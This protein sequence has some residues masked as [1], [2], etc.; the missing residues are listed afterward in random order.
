[1]MLNWS[2]GGH[3]ERHGESGVVTPPG[4]SVKGVQGARGA[5]D[6]QQPGEGEG[7]VFGGNMPVAH[8]GAATAAPASRRPGGA[9]AVA[10]AS[11]RVRDS[12]AGSAGAAGR[13]AE[14]RP[15][16]RH[17]GEQS[18]ATGS[19]SDDVVRAAPA[20]DS[21]EGAQTARGVQGGSLQ[22]CPGRAGGAAPAPHAHQRR[23]GVFWQVEAAR[24]QR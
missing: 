11:S 14:A 15:G 6:R 13:A 22:G 5:G 7:R 18:N 4:R 3:K 2:S 17:Q 9:A 16:G 21:S 1:M 24:L 8:G 23:R 20:D 12:G 19:S 10:E